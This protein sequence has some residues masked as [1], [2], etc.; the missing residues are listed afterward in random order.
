MENAG[1]DRGSSIPVADG[2]GI[3][4]AVQACM[5]SGQGYY[6]SSAGRRPAH[7]AGLLCAGGMMLLVPSG[8]LLLILTLLKGDV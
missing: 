7:T 6:D 5:G 2:K 3:R 1:S 4:I 8:L